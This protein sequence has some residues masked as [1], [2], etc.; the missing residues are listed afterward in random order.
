MGLFDGTSLERPVLCDR[1]N[2]PEAECN[3]PPAV[4]VVERVPPEKQKARIAVEKRKKGKVV[5]VVR[6]LDSA[7]LPELVTHLKN[8]CGAG[9]SIQDGTI[10]IQ[11]KHA[12]RVRAELTTRGYRT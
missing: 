9:G 12:D 1:C 2:A 11:G 10:E 4:E 5:T 6:G 8:K 7:D 3:C